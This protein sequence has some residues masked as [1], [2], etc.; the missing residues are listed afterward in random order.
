MIALC[1]SSF[2]VAPEQIAAG[3]TR[4]VAVDPSGD[5]VSAGFIS[6]VVDNNDDFI[7]VKLSGTD[8]GELWRYVPGTQIPAFAVVLDATAN[9]LAAGGGVVKLDGA[10][11]AEL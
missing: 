1:Q 11:G 10:T 6:P 3:D 8:G 7:V 9:V 4:S 2:P 5:V